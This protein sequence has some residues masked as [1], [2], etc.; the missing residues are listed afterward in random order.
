MST[1]A[2]VKVQQ[3][4]LNWEQAV[5]LYHHYDGYPDTHH[6]MI[7]QF[8]KAYEQCRDSYEGGRAGKVA[9]YLCVQDPGGFEP[10]EGH[11]LHYDIDFYYVLTAENH[12]CGSM[13][14]RPTW[15]VEV[16]SVEQ[17]YSA[18]PSPLKLTSV[19]KGSLAE[20]HSRFVGSVVSNS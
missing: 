12:G 8:W 11:A 4:G 9:S 2:Q 17:E 15:A 18:S 3:A 19:F 10:E 5:T 13:A 1:R 6:G 16:F 7:Q 20:A 14:E